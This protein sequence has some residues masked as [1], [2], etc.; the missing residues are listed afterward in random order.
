MKASE[1]MGS[2][3]DQSLAS[4]FHQIYAQQ[5]TFNGSAINGRHLR[6]GDK[7]NNI[8]R[9]FGATEAYA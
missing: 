6:P 1:N 2:D 9:I 4:G 5:A 8:H 7:L 3:I